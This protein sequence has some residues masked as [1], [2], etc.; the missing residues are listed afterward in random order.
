MSSSES[1]SKVNVFGLRINLELLGIFI[2][3]TPVGA[4]LGLQLPPYTLWKGVGIVRGA[5]LLVSL[6]HR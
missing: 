1:N 4:Y 6:R 5:Y 2:A 3:L